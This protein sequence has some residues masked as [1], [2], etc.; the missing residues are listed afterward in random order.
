MC[1][2]PY[3]CGFGHE[4]IVKL[5]SVPKRLTAFS[6]KSRNLL[7]PIT[8][9]H[10]NLSFCL[11]VA[12]CI[13]LSACGFRRTVDLVH[14]NLSSSEASA[15]THRSHWESLA[16]I[17][18]GHISKENCD[19]GDSVLFGGLLCW[20]GDERGCELVRRS[21]GTDGRWWRSPRRN[22][23]NL[24]EPK[25][26]SRDMASG[27][28]LYLATTKDTAAAERW[29]K[30]IEDN[31]PCVKPAA[32]SLSDK[33]V[34]PGPHRFCTDGPQQMCTLTP[35]SWANMG[36]VWSYLG[37]DK[38]QL[39]KVN[40]GADDAPGPFS[41]VSRVKTTPLGYQLHL[42]AAEILMKMKLDIQRDHV[43]GAASM[44][45]QRQPENPYFQFLSG[46]DQVIVWQNVLTLCPKPGEPDARRYQWSWE[47]DTSE[48]A[49]NESMGWDC[50][51]MDRLLTDR[52]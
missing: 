32:E 44:L 13:W 35:A 49:W 15:M 41:L 38:H 50:I 9:G 29:L 3:A 34:I 18:E 8:G 23:G 31:R 25:S 28:L 26:F 7:D 30:W 11:A 5:K 17:C 6:A 24:S 1:C 40:S 46:E 42:V 2:N 45:S 16:P 4:I 37:L 21:Q 20:S 33:C 27:V 52:D 10:M 48:A 39:M 36:H 12:S 22:P 47:R 19:D 43:K 51:F 14:S